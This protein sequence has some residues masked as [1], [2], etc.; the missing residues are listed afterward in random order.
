MQA[1]V[2]RELLVAYSRFVDDLFSADRAGE[3]RF[4]FTGPAGAAECAQRLIELTG[5]ELETAKR[6][7]A[8]A[9]ATML[10]VDVSAVPGALIFRIGPLKRDKWLETI[11]TAL[12]E[13]FLRPGEAKRLAGRL[14]WAGTVVF[15]RGARAYLSALHWHAHGRSG[16]LTARVRAALR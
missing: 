15:G 3:G 5:W 13:D 1:L 4:E 14:G 2:A 10:G 12:R 9:E 6:V 16:R 11:K 7:R 8:A